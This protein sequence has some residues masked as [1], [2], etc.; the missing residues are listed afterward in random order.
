M[1]LSVSVLYNE[2]TLLSYTLALF[3]MKEGYNLTLVGEKGMLVCRNFAA[4]LSPD[5]S[6]VI[7]LMSKENEV[8][9]IPVPNYEGAHGGGDSRLLEMMFCGAT[10]DPLGQSADSF[11]G[12]CSAMIGIGANESIRT[13]KVYDIASA[14]PRGRSLNLS[15]S[16]AESAIIRIP[17]C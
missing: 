12:V 16:L 3:A 4:E 8:Q 11:A 5:E 17:L 13:G 7:E 9:R 2:G 15:K 1:N 6:Y 10:Q 14:C